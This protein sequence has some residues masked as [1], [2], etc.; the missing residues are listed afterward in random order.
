MRQTTIS[1]FD[2]LLIVFAV[3]GVLFVFTELTRITSPEPAPIISIN[4]NLVDTRRKE[5]TAG[6]HVKGLLRI[7][8]DKIVC[9]FA[10][11]FLWKWL[12]R[13]V[14]GWWA[15]ISRQ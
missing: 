8:W 15:V 12:P 4:I 1:L 14:G 13:A 10:I 9:A 11:Q 7:T 5:L 6:D 2:L 3:I